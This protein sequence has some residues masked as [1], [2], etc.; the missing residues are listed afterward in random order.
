MRVLLDDLPDW[1][2][3]DV[4]GCDECRTHDSSAFVC[5][6]HE[7]V[8]AAVR[9]VEVTAGTLVREERDA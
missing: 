9:I 2:R 3:K 5:G 1:A 8:V 7:N 4:K 6:W